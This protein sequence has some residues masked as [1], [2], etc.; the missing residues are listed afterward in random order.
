M[1]VVHF[2][3]MPQRPA[4]ESVA[5]VSK[6]PSGGAPRRTFMLKTQ[7]KRL[8]RRTLN[9]TRNQTPNEILHE[10]LEQSC[11]TLNQIPNESLNEPGAPSC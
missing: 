3:C 1:Q 9:E 4:S 2:K 5:K 11:E 10:T 7:P 6:P 8:F